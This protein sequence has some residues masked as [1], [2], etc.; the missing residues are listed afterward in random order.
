MVSSYE[1]CEVSGHQSISTEAV[2]LKN[3]PPSLLVGDDW[4]ALPLILGRF[5]RFALP[6]EILASGFLFRLGKGKS[7]SS[8]ISTS[9]LEA[10]VEE[11]TSDSA[12]CLRIGEGEMY[13]STNLKNKQFVDR[14]MDVGTEP[15][16]R[17]Y[18]K[19]A[20]LST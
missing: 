9:S 11:G 3:A 17:V 6:G 4:L 7:S 16:L 10:G 12:S 1:T 13:L 19:V 18:D 5:T 8:I 14:G 15:F 2:T 20:S